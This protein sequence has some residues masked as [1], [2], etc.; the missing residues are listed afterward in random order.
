MADGSGGA[1]ASTVAADA[2]AS[3]SVS[4]GASSTTSTGTG[5]VPA[6]DDRRCGDDGC[7]GFC[8][9]READATWRLDFAP[10][11]GRRLLSWPET[12][13][14]FVLEERN[15]I[16][17]VDTCDGSVLASRVV[18]QDGAQLLAATVDGDEIVVVVEGATGA[19]LERLDARTLAPGAPAVLLDRGPF[20]FGVR[21]GD[22]FLLPLANDAALAR[23]DLTGMGCAADSTYVDPGRVV[24]VAGN[25]VFASFTRHD[26]GNARSRISDFTGIDAQCAPATRI[27]DF[28]GGSFEPFALLVDGTNLFA[29]GAAT[30]AGN[31]EASLRPFVSRLSLADLVVTASWQGQSLGIFTAHGFYDGAVVG[32]NVIGVGQRGGEMNAFQGDGLVVSMPTDFGSDTVP[33][34]TTYP[35]VHRLSAIVAE[36]DAVYVTGRQ[37]VMGNQG[38]FVVRCTT[39]LDC[40]L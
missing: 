15:E 39:A 36:P 9:G 21:S 35:S 8:E 34:E 30:R 13:S 2:S 3:A 4:D 14:L 33:T 23:F 18:G 32:G 11:S 28:L 19:L 6:C 31:G 10:G 5:C 22:A 12:Q 20:R 17:R 37:S 40:P 1:E 16:L 38:G 24:A 29:V 7:G 27:S 26:E 25:Q